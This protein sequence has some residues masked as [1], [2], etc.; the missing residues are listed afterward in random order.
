MISLTPAAAEQVRV[1]ARE[2]KSEGLPL[3]VAVTRLPDGSFHYAMG[4]DDNEHEGDRHF[5][6]EG[7]DI[8]VAPPSLE[9]LDG[10]VIDYVELDGNMEIIFINPND[11]A[12]KQE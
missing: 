6:S 5:Q 3:R 7:I 11:P 10:T 1:S 4:F 9:L 2:G 12:R 8:V